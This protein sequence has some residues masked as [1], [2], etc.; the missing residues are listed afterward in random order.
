[1]SSDEVIPF[2]GTLSFEQYRRAQLLHLKDSVTRWSVIVAL[3]AIGVFLLAV[4]LA[5]DQPSWSSAGFLVPSA[6]LLLLRVLQERSYRRTWRSHQLARERIR[7]QLSDHGLAIEGEYGSARI[8]WD[9]LYRWRA[10]DDLLLIYEGS[11]AMHLLPRAFFAGEEDW[12]AARD[13]IA[14]KLSTMETHTRWS[15]VKQLLLWV[16][17][18]IVLVL[19]YAAWAGKG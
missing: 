9:R 19:L 8:P 10:A 4:N 18:F 17:I 14:A 6:A 7:G 2:A 16:A 13:L 12:Q 15:S 5:S 1:M 11:N 3:G